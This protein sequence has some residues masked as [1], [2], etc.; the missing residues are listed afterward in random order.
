MPYSFSLLMT[1]HFSPGL[2][3]RIDD[4]EYRHPNGTHMQKGRDSAVERQHIV[5]LKQSTDSLELIE[6]PGIVLFLEA[7]QE[8]P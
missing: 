4:S 5:W 1:R 2:F 7:A 3:P 8:D 6:V